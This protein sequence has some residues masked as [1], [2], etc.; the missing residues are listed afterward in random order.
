N[1]NNNIYLTSKTWDTNNYLTPTFKVKRF[2]VFKTY[3]FFI[4]EVKEIYKSKLKGNTRSSTISDKVVAVKDTKNCKETLNKSEN[5][6]LHKSK[7]KYPEKNLEKKEEITENKK[8]K[9][10]ATNVTQEKEQNN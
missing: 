6:D 9:L 10:R 4:D 5:N 8:V 7:P 1:I 2:H 3:A